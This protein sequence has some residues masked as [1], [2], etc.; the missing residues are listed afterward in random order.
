MEAPIRTLI[1]A[2]KR[3]SRNRDAVTIQFI[4]FG[5]DKTGRARLAWLDDELPKSGPEYFRD[6]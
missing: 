2:L 5:D 1:A 3:N 6:L 4:R